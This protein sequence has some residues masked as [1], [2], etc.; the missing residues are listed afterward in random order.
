M[1]EQKGL[2]AIITE[3]INKPYSSV[4][5]MGAIGLIG[6]SS[7]F[8]TYQESTEQT[9]I[10][11]T[12]DTALPAMSKK[13]F[14]NNKY[15]NASL[16]SSE[17]EQDAITLPDLSAEE[18]EP[19]TL[20][21]EQSRKSVDKGFSS[22]EDVSY[23]VK[24]SSQTPSS[25]QSRSQVRSHFNQRLDERTKDNEQTILQMTAPAPLSAEELADRRTK[26]E[27]LA[28]AAQLEQMAIEGLERVHNGPVQMAGNDPSRSLSGNSQNI[29]SVSSTY[30]TSNGSSLPPAQVTLAN[31]DEYVAIPDGRQL[32][33]SFYGLK[34]ERKQPEMISSKPVPN[35]IE[36]VIHGDADQ[37]TVTNGSTIK[38]RL[39]QDIQV[40]T[41]LLQRN[42]LLS[43]ECMIS[44][45]RVQVFLTSVRV[46]SSIIPIKMRVYDIDGHSGI[47]VPDLAVKNQ[48]AQTGAQTVTGGSL[49]MPYMI[50]SGGS[51]AEM[52]VGQTAVQGANLAVNGIR[53]LAAKKISQ[54]KVTIRPNYRV[55]L[56][57]DQ[58]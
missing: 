21:S 5:L 33:N 27:S 25:W 7:G 14:K 20:P 30:L 32:Q 43:G 34:G 17:D 39:L 42:S 41:Y 15:D 13:V 56:K 23:R 48:L 46:N 45:E 53:T 22:N 8:I 26:E 29:N 31:L 35:A 19:R 11:Q 50:P 37:V 58:N 44:G 36:A 10:S 28:K 54:Q 12:L 24:A 52:L 18:E 51:M 1:Q 55:Y 49:N 3:I 6:I 57:Q 38:L 47:Y 40:G 9:V 2:A 4:A 16:T